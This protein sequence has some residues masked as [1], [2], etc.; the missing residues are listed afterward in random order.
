MEDADRLDLH[1]D[2]QRT[3]D[4]A[5]HTRAT[6]DS[7][8]DHQRRTHHDHRGNH[9]HHVDD[10]AGPHVH[11]LDDL[12]SRSRTRWSLQPR[13]DGSQLHLSAGADGEA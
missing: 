10:H 11:D 5:A 7:C 9:D 3:G 13:S 8:P 2:Q 12:R 1:L 6:H 4:S